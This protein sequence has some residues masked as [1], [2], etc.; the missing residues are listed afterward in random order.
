MNL[1]SLEKIDIETLSFQ[2]LI[3]KLEILRKNKERILSNNKIDEINKIQTLEN[4]IYFQQKAFQHMETITKNP[5]Y[6]ALNLTYISDNYSS[7]SKYKQ[8][9]INLTKSIHKRFKAEDVFKTLALTNSR[10]RNLER[11][12]LELLDLNEIEGSIFFFNRA[13]LQNRLLDKKPNFLGKKR[14]NP[15]LLYKN[16]SLE[17]SKKQQIKPA[18]NYRVKALIL[19]KKTQYTPP[20]VFAHHYLNIGNLLLKDVQYTK[21]FKYLK[22]AQEFEKQ[23]NQKEKN[24]FPSEFL[25]NRIQYLFE[26]G[27][28]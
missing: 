23:I 5:Y 3:E 2:Q 7:L 14:P 10:I 19:S 27:Y 17:F 28:F 9:E 15:E 22:K 6:L 20:L 26:K 24:N 11:I 25:E 12:G 1:T 18:L 4:I 13:G 8:K 16:A 21:A